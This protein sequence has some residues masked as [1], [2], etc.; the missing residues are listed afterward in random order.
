MSINAYDI[1]YLG[2]NNN[3][4]MKILREG[5][6]D[7]SISYLRNCKTFAEFL[8][9]DCEYKGPL[10]KQSIMEFLYPKP[11]EI[12]DPF[13]MERR[14]DDEYYNNEIEQ[15][16]KLRA[17]IDNRIKELKYTENEIEDLMNIPVS[18]SET[19]KSHEERYKNYFQESTQNLLDGCF[20]EMLSEEGTKFIKKHKL[21]FIEDGY[22]CILY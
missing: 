16:E 4:L 22:L 17:E 8:N 3:E 15:L 7:V 21:Q 12:D 18:E 14:H 11:D 10:N 19:Q 2:F 20:D 13:Y 6:R 5:N 9:K 1:R